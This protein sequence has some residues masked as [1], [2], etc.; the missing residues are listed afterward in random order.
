ML[1]CFVFLVLFV[2]CFAEQQAGLVEH[3]VTL[4]YS[5]EYFSLNTSLPVLG[6]FVGVD[7]PATT[8]KSKPLGK[9][10]P[11][12]C[13]QYADANC[14][15]VSKT[16]CP[17][18]YVLFGNQCNKPELKCVACLEIA[19]WLGTG[20]AAAGAAAACKAISS[21]MP[22]GTRTIAKIACNFLVDRYLDKAIDMLTHG[23]TAH[24]VC[25]ALAYSE[26]KP[27][28]LASFPVNQGGCDY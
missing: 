13:C 18:D 6:G 5:D 7:C 14:C 20:G 26:N 25:E 27:F 4:S 21:K 15:M 28:C 22:F 24:A 10:Y 8:C 2:C 19:R 11:Q 9:D 23:A 12:F 16:C 3:P 17:K 1:K